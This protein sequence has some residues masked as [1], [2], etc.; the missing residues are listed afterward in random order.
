MTATKV[1]GGE[2][3]GETRRLP[4]RGPRMERARRPGP[5]GPYRLNTTGRVAV[6]SP[7]CRR[8]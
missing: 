3:L 4:P 5:S 7:A 8:A 2:S 6:Y 1:T